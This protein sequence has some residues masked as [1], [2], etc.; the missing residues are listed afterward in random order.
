MK[1]QH[2]GSDLIKY[3]GLYF[4]FSEAMNKIISNRN[5]VFISLVGSNGSETLVLVA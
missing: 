1:N 3:R 2:L 4:T 5:Q